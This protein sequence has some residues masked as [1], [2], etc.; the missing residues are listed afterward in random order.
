MK[1]LKYLSGPGYIKP[2]YLIEDAAKANSVIMFALSDVINQLEE[3][4]CDIFE[5]RDAS[6]KLN[7]LINSSM[8]KLGLPGAEHGLRSEVDQLFLDR[9][10]EL[11]K[12]CADAIESGQSDIYEGIDK[13]NIYDVRK[14]ISHLRVND[15]NAYPNREPEIMQGS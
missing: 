8:L 5:M 2:D 1:K 14:I 6:I 12:E 11:D 7:S 3:G 10:D 4:G 9:L 15:L 13:N